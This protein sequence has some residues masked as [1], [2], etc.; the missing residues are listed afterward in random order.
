MPHGDVIHV[1]DLV[2]RAGVHR[3]AISTDR[4]PGREVASVRHPGEGLPDLWTPSPAARAPPALGTAIAVVLHGLLALG[5]VN[6]DPAR[7]RAEEPI[8]IDVDEKLPPPEVKP[9]PPPEAKPPPER[10]RASCT[11][12]PTSRRRR[13]TPP[14]PSEEPPK[15]DEPPPTFGVALS[16]TTA[17]DSSVAVPIGNTLMTKPGP[18]PEKPK[19]PL[20]ATA[21]GGFVPVAEI[22]IS[23]HAENIFDAGRR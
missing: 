20:Q 10:A 1:I 2:K 22:Y 16:A 23:K 15:A 11:A 5:V 19:P 18:K 17:G 12:C 14:P 8:E 7:F 21:R 4:E 13:P 9:P 6:I 3:F